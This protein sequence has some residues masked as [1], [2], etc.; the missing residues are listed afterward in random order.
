[1]G[2]GAFIWVPLSLALG[3]RPVF[4]LAALLTFI[5]TLGAGYARTIGELLVYVCLLGMGEAFALTSVCQ[6]FVIC[7]LSLY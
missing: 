2:I 3:R 5:A 7:C 1:M 4:L 6:H